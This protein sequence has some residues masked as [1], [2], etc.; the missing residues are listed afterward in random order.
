MGINIS[1]FFVFSDNDT[2]HANVYYLGIQAYGKVGMVTPR[3]E[4]VY[5]TGNAD[6]K[7]IGNGLGEQD[8]DI[9][10]WAAFGALEFNISPA[11]NPYIGGYYYSGDDDNNDDDLEGF[12][13]ISNCARYA[14]TFGV[15]NGIIFRYVPA[16]GTHLYDGTPNMLGNSGSGYGSISNSGSAQFPGLL[17][18]GIGLNGKQGALFYKT[19]FQYFWLDDTGALEDYYETQHGQTISYDDQLG[20]EFDL[21]LSYK[22]GNHFSIGNT[23]S[24]FSPGDFIEDYWG[25]DY[26]S[27]AYLDAIELKWS[28]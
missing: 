22:F 4:F 15:E 18:L 21:Y 16:L 11:I 6:N 23:L 13:A 3:F 12:N 24:I 2:A 26:D 25:D 28:F 27:T 8:Y 14:P 19:Q 7:D 1:P 17:S 10:A 5:V 20:W 9:K